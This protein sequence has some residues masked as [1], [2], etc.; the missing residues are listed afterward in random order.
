[1]TW[2]IL[3]LCADFFILAGSI[4]QVGG[5]FWLKHQAKKD[6]VKNKPRSLP[7]GAIAINFS[8]SGDNFD[9]FGF[10]S[11]GVG[12][13]YLILN[14]FGFGSASN[15]LF[16]LCLIQ[17]AFL[18]I[19]GFEIYAVEAENSV[20]VY[21]WRTWP[22]HIRLFIIPFFGSAMMAVIV[23]VMAAV[24]FLDVLTGLPLIVV[25]LALVIYVGKSTD[26]VTLRQKEPRFWRGPFRKP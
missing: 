17:S 23:G 9:I 26:T 4:L 19:A 14:D 3:A 7:A 8:A 21:M 25:S 2:D 20:E 11:I 6:L 5:K 15:L 22:M 24:G 10:L 16:A 12:S 18:V 1:L 13:V